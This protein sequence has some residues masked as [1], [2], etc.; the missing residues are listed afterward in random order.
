MI[1]LVLLAAAIACDDAGL[2]DARR[3]AWCGFHMME[4]K[5]KTDRRLARANGREAG[6][7]PSS[8]REH[9]GEQIE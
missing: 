8:P 9:V 3:L 1:R 5:R 7:A 6:H 2:A 4:L